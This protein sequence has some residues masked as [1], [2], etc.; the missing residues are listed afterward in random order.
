ML[1]DV[2]GKV[3]RR[4][5]QTYST[6]EDAEPIETRCAGDGGTTSKQ[7]QLK[8]STASE[9]F[10]QVGDKEKAKVPVVITSLIGKCQEKHQ[11]A[12]TCPLGRQFW[13]QDSKTAVEVLKLL[14]S[15]AHVHSH[16]WSVLR[17]C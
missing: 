7:A 9:Q 15:P 3:D 4:D 13:V 1:D 14:N 5:E 2:W 10:L 11:H 17:H 6:F 8:N 16:Y 12:P